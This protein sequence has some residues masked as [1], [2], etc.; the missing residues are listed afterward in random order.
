M[1]VFPF[2]FPSF[3]GGPPPTEDADGCWIGLPSQFER[4]LQDTLPS[5]AIDQLRLRLLFA[6]VDGHDLTKGARALL[7]MACETE[8]RAVLVKVMTLTTDVLVSNVCERRKYVEIDADMRAHGY[9]VAPA[10]E[11]LK[12]LPAIPRPYVDLV[13]RY[14]DSHYPKYRV[15]ALATTVCLAAA[16]SA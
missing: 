11:E 4:R 1:S 13:S 3:F 12:E 5:Y 9:L 14:L 8:L 7:Q 15:S 2:G 10:I 6:V 16:V